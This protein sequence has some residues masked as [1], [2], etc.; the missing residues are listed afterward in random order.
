MS[1]HQAPP[2]VGGYGAVG[3]LWLWML[4]LLLVLAPVQASA[5]VPS[6]V[7][8]LAIA[9]EAGPDKAS[10]TIHATLK[11]PSTLDTVIHATR[12]AHSVL[13]AHD[14]LRHTI[15]LEVDVIQGAPEEIVFRLDG[16]GEVERVRGTALRDWG[17]RQG[18]DG[19]RQLV[20][21]LAQSEEPVKSFS[22]TVTA[23]TKLDELARAIVPLRVAAEPASLFSGYLRLS[24]VPELTVL[25]EATSGVTPLDPA[26]LPESMRVKP[27][28]GSADPMAY[29]FFG[30]PY[31]YT[32]RLAPTDPELHRVVLR[33]FVLT[34]RL[35]EDGAAFLLEAIA[36]VRNPRGGSLDLLRGAAALTRIDSHPDWRVRLDGDRYQL[37]F[38]RSGEYPVRL[39]FNALIRRV[40]GWNEVD[41]AVAPSALQPVELVGLAEDTEFRFA[42]AARPERVGNRFVSHLPPSGRVKLAWK[43]ARREVEGRLFYAADALGQVTIR[44]GLMRHTT[45]LF[46][47]VMQGELQ[48]VE[49]RLDGDGEVTHV[50]GRNVLAWSI[51][52][53]S[54]P[55]ER[56]LLIRLNQPQQDEFA[57]QVQTQTALGVFPQVIDPV[58][59][60]PVDATR[61]GGH[62]RIINEG[63]VRLE[64]LDASGLSQISPEQFPR[65]EQTRAVFV[66]QP[67][68]EFAYRFSG[69]DY[70]LRVQAD[71][72]LPEV[73]VSQLLTYHLGETEFVVEAE[74]ELD[75]REAPVRELGLRI[76]SG[77]AVA[78]LQASGL[79]DY[80]V[81]DTT[82]DGQAEL[83]LIYVAPAFGRQ[84]IQLRLERSNLL[85]QTAWALPRIEVIKARSARGHVGVSSDPGLRLSAT[86]TDGLTEIA[87]AYFPKQVRNIQAAFRLSDPDWRAT[88]GIERLAQSIQADV[89]HLFSVAEGL[90][91][92][93]SVMNYL[94]AGA[95]IAQFRVELSDE[96]FNVEFT[97]N[98]IRNWQKTESGYEIHLHTPVA[99]P[100]SLLATFERPFSAQGET[101]TFTGA[102]PLDAQSEQG[103]TIVISSFQ[104]QVQPAR[105]STGLR[106]LEPGE[107]PGE[108]RLFFDAPILAAYHYTSRPFELELELK[109]LTQGDTVNQ[110]VDRAAL[111]T[112]VSETGQV[113]TDARYYFK[114]KAAPHLRVV[115]PD[116]DTRLWSATVNGRSVVPVQ[117]GPASLV[118]LPQGPDPDAVQ[119]LELK[120]ASNSSNPKRLTVIAPSLSAPVLLTEWRLEPEA[121]RRLVYRGGSLTPATALLDES[122]FAGLARLFGGRSAERAW[123]NLC[124]ALALLVVAILVW[125]VATREGTCRFSA[126]HSSGLILGV[127]ACGMAVVLLVGVAQLAGTETVSP[128]AH[129]SFVAPVQAAGET[130]TIE[131]LNLPLERSAFAVIGL[132]WPALFGLAAWVHALLQPAGFQRFI[133][134]AVGWTFWFWTALRW[135]N[136]ASIVVLMVVA[137]VLI[138][139]VWPGLRQLWR[140]PPRSSTGECALPSSATPL[141]VG[142]LFLCLFETMHAANPPVTHTQSAEP[143]LGES[144][145]QT[146]RVEAGF[147][148][149]TATI[150]WTAEKGQTLDLLRAPGVLTRAV[151]PPSALKLVQSG[152]DSNRRH[153]LLALDSGAHDIE[154]EY[155]IHVLEKDGQLGFHLPVQPGLINRLRLELEAPDVEVNSPRAVSV[156]A[157][158][159]TDTTGTV[160]DLVLSPVPDAWIGWTPRTRDTRRETTVFYAELTQL[161]VPIAGVI[162]GAHAV[163]LRPA[164]GEIGD[165]TFRVPEPLT[166]TDVVG[167]P[168][169][170][171]RF[172]PD[173]RTLRVTLNPPQAAPFNLL[174]RSQIATRPLPYDQA[175][176]IISVA[177][178]AGQVGF[179]GVATG[180]DVQ[181]EHLEAT[182]FTPVNLEDF[183]TS[184]LDA[185]TSR[186]PGLTLRRAFRHSDFDA[187]LELRAAAVEPDVRV[188]TQETLS[189]GEDRVVLAV[190]LGVEISRAGIFRLSFT[191]PPGMD[192]ESISG[193]ALSHWTEL[194]TEDQRIITLHLRGKTEG[195]QRFALTLAG[196]GARAA[197]DWAPPR[198][199]VREASKQ[200]GQLVVVP[201]QGLRIGVRTREGVTQLDP[202]RAGIR[203]KGALAFRLLHAQWNLAF[204]LEPVAAWVQVTSLQD[205]AVLGGQIKVA[206]HF[207]YQIENTGI[208]SLRVRLPAQADSVRFSGD[209]VADYLPVQDAAGTRTRTWEIK[210][211]RR[212]IGAYLLQASYHLPLEPD[213]VETTLLGAQADDVNLQRGFLTLHS[214]GRLQVRVDAV[215]DALQSTDWQA[216]PRSLRR[217]VDSAPA[218]YTFRLV[219]PD[220]QLPVRL[221][222]HEPA[223]LLPA[224]VESVTLTS[225]LADNGAMLTQARLA[226]HPG[227]KRLLHLTLPDGAR[228]W[229]AFVNRNSVWPWRQNDQILIPLDAPTQAGQLST[230]EF[231]Y[232]SHAGRARP[233]ALD[234]ALHGPRFDLPL[235]N[236]TWQVHLDDKWRL[237]DWGGSLQYQGQTTLAVP[238]QLA[239]YLAT[240]SARQQARTRE[241]EQLLETGNTL[242]AR[243]DPQQARRAFQAAYGLSQHDDAF[244][245]DARVQLQNL[246]LQQALVGLNVR[247]DAAFADPGAAQP[248]RDPRRTTAYTQAEARQ[249]IDRNTAE[250]NTVLFRLAERF[251]QQQEAAVA[252]PAAIRAALPEHGRRLTFTR[253]LFIDPWAELRVDIK[254][255][256][257]GPARFARF[258]ALA[259][260]LLAIVVVLHLLARI[261]HGRTSE[262]KSDAIP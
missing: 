60:R 231:Y 122:G 162:E 7:E 97:G 72:I 146:A 137:F 237:D 250:E 114:S 235:E 142:A 226:L 261:L 18:T 258:L 106:P 186:V 139:L 84:V 149:V 243:G 199:I 26:F 39:R 87:T 113:L 255:V 78:R 77:Y 219:E 63:A 98:E 150:R 85:T 5:A 170:L 51:E 73:A 8:R 112:R 115:L 245:E 70:G 116:D 1:K 126:R 239:D 54:D 230:V 49:L 56:R 36:G 22:A 216:I 188:T 3:S 177:A 46:F 83:R 166:I 92:G 107:V 15:E 246:K 253:S 234:F 101:L 257:V 200:T 30:A 203:Q 59:L 206:A 185:L 89:F 157:Q 23:V 68:Q 9:G 228:F 109:P 173:N 28:E 21:R 121:G 81:S 182:P 43:E 213:L 147:V 103:H 65:N 193:D 119:T 117:D 148:F 163:R 58:R 260:L 29:R 52:P 212:V 227:D 184:A 34:G 262:A 183:P 12:V 131:V 165:L 217:G 17:V 218:A 4:G 35:D 232:L 181:L 37:V 66:D 123:A 110:I 229:F 175:A 79:G 125:R 100:Y 164:Q 180:T 215:P 105:I 209:Q 223:R 130:T 251:I 259:G 195:E 10:L 6:E 256:A 238:Q 20:L 155:Q 169:S 197:T 167:E 242:L 74:L 240:E 225:V 233:R 134:I 133:G 252:T 205:V 159:R 176:P 38:D 129:L 136:G 61:F 80:I 95:P 40:E 192:A 45:L 172:D 48:Q 86:I 154:I 69:S 128:A 179:L 25:V 202:L 144:V 67:G 221:E 156:V 191:L 62:L 19:G 207:E 16:A 135:P 211:H 124:G 27:T 236:V 152:P 99:G 210:L 132:L 160:A 143:A 161:Y 75:I 208:R 194:R 140:V 220:F 14:A 104:F 57:I 2:D 247:R 88:L 222:R 190:Q 31:S 13:G 248:L 108:Y 90:A 127:I 254:A 168:V 201:E 249:L 64:V 174:L 42:G 111:E 189:L 204:D 141:L 82:E 50:Q 96:Y 196:P 55:G 151:Y 76:P 102:R 94:I 187:R 71:N 24:A 44:P 47:K 244:N 171:W 120:L 158:P 33:D 53:A 198:L 91:Y 11:G 224:R 241:A 145:I 118:P 138:H 153:G 32:M 93:S 214:A 178:A 41:F